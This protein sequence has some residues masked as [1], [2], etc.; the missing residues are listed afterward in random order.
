MNHKLLLLLL[1]LLL[2]V[3]LYQRVWLNLARTSVTAAPSAF[4]PPS[5][6][7]SE[8]LV[9][10]PVAACVPWLGFLISERRSAQEVKR[11]LRDAP[12]NFSKHCSTTLIPYGL[13]K[14][15]NSSLSCLHN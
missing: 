15:L 14:G 4:F 13:R 5:E 12:V 8:E 6:E 9:F 7:L 3:L 10:P 2:L 11:D 1:L